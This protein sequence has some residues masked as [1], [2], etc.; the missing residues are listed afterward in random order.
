MGIFGLLLAIGLNAQVLLAE[1][2]SKPFGWAR[3]LS[4][5]VWEP[6]EAVS[7]FVGL[8]LP[9]LW[10]DEAL[11][12]GDTETVATGTAGS[13]TGTGAA[14]DNGTD[15]TGGTGDTDSASGGSGTADPNTDDA[16]T[17]D[18]GSTTD[19]NNNTDPTSATSQIPVPT[20]TNPLNMWVIGDS[21]THFFGDEMVQ[22]AIDTGIITAETESQISSGL[23]RPDYFDWPGRL[24]EI[25]IEES[26]DVVVI[27]LGGNDAQGLAVGSRVLA[28]LSQDWQAEYSTR[29]GHVM[30]LV[31]TDPGRVLIWGG[32]PIMRDTSFDAKMQQLNAIYQAEAAKRDRVAFVPSRELFSD[33]NGQYSRFLTDENGQ[34]VDARLNDGIHFST[35]GGV[36]MS[37]LLL[38]AVGEHVDLQTGRPAS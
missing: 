9:R 21:L 6:V 28:T 30:D 20:P 2:E 1:A 15:P 11:N 22:L 26:P 4:V 3:D 18:T 19:P 31:T 29:V 12:R 7:S 8:H 35:A 34:L 37:E 38:G 32:I 5:A 14:G 17:G 33:A 36:L 27:T 16:S 25:L 24:T 23:S 10:L 13:G